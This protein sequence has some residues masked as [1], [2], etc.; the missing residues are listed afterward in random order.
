MNHHV[1]ARLRQLYEKAGGSGECGRLVEFCEFAAH[2]IYTDP[3]HF[4]KMQQEGIF[5]E[6]WVQVTRPEVED[7]LIVRDAETGKLLGIFSITA[8]NAPRQFIT[9]ENVV[10]G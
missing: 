4:H 9:I 7:L 1:A 6:Y 3:A 10:L 2:Q 8:V 5:R